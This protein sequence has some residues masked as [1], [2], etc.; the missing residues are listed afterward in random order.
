MDIVYIYKRFPGGR[1]LQYSLRSACKNLRFDSIHIV[2]DEPPFPFAGNHIAVRGPHGK[3]ENGFAK[4]RAAIDSREVSDSFILMNDDFFILHPFT[5]I[6]YIYMNKLADW[7][8]GFPHRSGY[9]DKAI[10]TLE[11]VGP[12]AKIFEV[13]FPVVYEKE[14]L[15][16]LIAKYSLPC[17]LMLRTLYCHT[18]KIQG[19]QSP[20]YKARSAGQ[21]AQYSQMRWFSTSEQ[22]ARTYTFQQTMKQ[23]FPTSCQFEN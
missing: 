3:H 9:Y 2:G 16:W 12:K 6:P 14:K 19:S 21:I 1:E 7:I 23:L 4:L 17:G 10:K 13:H 15:R 8:R 22:A 18:F 11:I 20:D 5:E